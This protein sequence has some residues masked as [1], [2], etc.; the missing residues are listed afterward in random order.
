MRFLM[1]S[2]ASSSWTPDKGRM[3]M[4]KAKRL[5]DAHA[6]MLEPCVPL[7]E[8]YKYAKSLVEALESG[9]LIVTTF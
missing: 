7:K 9:S 1:T 5:A 8:R 3:D 4:A 6:L 2:Q